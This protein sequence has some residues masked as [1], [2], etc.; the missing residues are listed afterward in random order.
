[1]DYLRF[2]RLASN[3]VAAVAVAMT[4][5][6]LTLASLTAFFF[7]P[8]PVLKLTSTELDS[9]IHSAIADSVAEL[10]QKSLA[11]L[12]QEIE[13][14]L[15]QVLQSSQSLADTEVAI[16]FENLDS[17][18]D[19]LAK[20][21]EIVEVIEQAINDSPERAM[22]IPILRKELDLLKSDVV[23]A[24]DALRAEIDR[25]YDL[26]KWFL[27]LM[28]TMAIA[29]MGLVIGNLIKRKE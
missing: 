9:R 13:E 8:D 11:E 15:D 25:I 29:V 28:A 27:G 6:G 23:E 24:V 18:L 2:F 7:P 14:A 12:R 16:R 1:M 5:I 4:I 20:Q 19:E 10:R 3:S 17:R 26:G 22:S 21:L